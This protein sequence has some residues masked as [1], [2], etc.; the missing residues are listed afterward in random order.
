MLGSK[1]S[2]GAGAIPGAHRSQFQR[3]KSN[4]SNTMTM[5]QHSARDGSQ[6]GR[7]AAFLYGL[8]AYLIFF[9]TFLYAIGFVEGI[10]VPKAIDTGAV[11]PMAE[12]LMDQHPADVAVCHPAQRHG[13]PAF[14][15][16]WTRFVPR[17]VERSTYV[18]LA[19]LALALL[20]WQWRPMPSLLA[21]RDPQLGA[22]SGLSFSAGRS[23][24]SALPH[25]PLRAVRAAPGRQSRRQ[26]DAR[27]GIPHAAALQSRA[28]PALFRLHDRLLVDAGHDRRAPAFAATTTVYILVGIPLE[29]RD[30]VALFGNQYRRYRKTAS[31]IIPWRKSA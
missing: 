6:I 3:P 15:R 4:R 31:M 1:P 23:C 19:S 16:W 2:A 13:A 5:I 10:I 7:L 8:V 26:R 17:P 9:V 12:A 30:L 28:S 21:R 29:E 14:K 24:C 20:C 25:Q 18:L 22:R 11:V 27:A